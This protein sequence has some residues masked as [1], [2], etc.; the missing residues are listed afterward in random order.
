MSLFS[1]VKAK[2]Q[3]F[4]ATPEG[5]KKALKRKKGIRVGKVVLIIALS[6]FAILFVIVALN[7]HFH[8][9]VTLPNMSIESEEAATSLRKAMP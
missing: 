8:W 6:A 2:R 5:Q 3:E 1:L 7:N 9:W 4:D